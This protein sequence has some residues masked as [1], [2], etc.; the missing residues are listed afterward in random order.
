[1]KVK[2]AVFIV[3]WTAFGIL[4][5]TSVTPSAALTVASKQGHLSDDA[6][7]YLA[8]LD[9][10]VEKL[11]KTFAERGWVRIP[12]AFGGSRLPEN[13]PQ[14]KKGS[15]KRPE[16]A[17]KEYVEKVVIPSNREAMNDEPRPYADT[18]QHVR[19]PEWET[20]DTFETETK[21]FAEKMERLMPKV[22]K[23]IREKVAKKHPAIRGW[24]LLSEREH[25]AKSKKIIWTEKELALSPIVQK[26]FDRVHGQRNGRLP[27]R[28]DGREAKDANE[29]SYWVLQSEQAITQETDDNGEA[30]PDQ[31]LAF[32][33]SNG[34]QK[35]WTLRYP[36]DKNARRHDP[37]SEAAMRE[38]Q[39]GEHWHIDQQTLEP[40][41]TGENGWNWQQFPKLNGWS[42]MH[43]LSLVTL[44]IYRDIE[45]PVG[46]GT[47]IVDKSHKL[48]WYLI[49][50]LRNRVANR[51]DDYPGRVKWW[52]ETDPDKSAAG[53]KSNQGSRW[54]RFFKEAIGRDNIKVSCPAAGAALKYFQAGRSKNGTSHWSEFS[55]YTRRR[56]TWGVKAGDLVVMHPNLVHTTTQNFSSKTRFASRFET[57]WNLNALGVKKEKDKDDRSWLAGSLQPALKRRDFKPFM[58]EI[59]EWDVSWGYNPEAACSE[60]WKNAHKWE[61]KSAEHDFC[62]RCRWKRFGWYHCAGTCRK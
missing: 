8:H 17:V 46:G 24:K 35:R 52:K 2:V 16:D 25:E 34:V 18:W 54:W 51:W 27:L 57:Y 43:S 47:G 10:E 41:E 33:P 59:D 44:P 7:T 19:V 58:F 28:M 49:A 62:S 48:L 29:V 21:N 45:T 60:W 36:V 53:M 40:D 38:T 6:Q 23:E 42:D 13:H 15:T 55:W 30:V 56:N 12:R 32:T 20:R 3:Y 11:A 61:G 31:S 39:E 9:E 1:M 5:S 4:M 14:F 22:E 26:F 37:W 50:D